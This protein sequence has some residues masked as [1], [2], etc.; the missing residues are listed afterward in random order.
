[1][2]GVPGMPIPVT[3]EADISVSYRYMYIYIYIYIY[4]YT[5]YR[6]SCDR[7][8]GFGF[9]TKQDEI[10]ANICREGRKEAR[11]ERLDW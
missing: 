4:I 1:M 2:N 9:V 3:T 6:N 10:L 7:E 8:D 5:L 11:K